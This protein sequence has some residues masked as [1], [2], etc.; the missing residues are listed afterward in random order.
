MKIGDKIKSFTIINIIDALDT[1]YSPSGQK[2]RKVFKFYLLK[3]DNGQERVLRADKKQLSESKKYFA[4][5][6][7]SKYIRHSMI[8]EYKK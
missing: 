5:N 8:K 4:I 2:I 6:G 7:N 3:S 1:F